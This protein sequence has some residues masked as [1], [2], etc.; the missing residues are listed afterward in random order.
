MLE[1]V[2]QNLTFLKFSVFI[3]AT[4]SYSFLSLV[5]VKI[6]YWNLDIYSPII[7]L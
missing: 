5:F 3:Q 4:F 7:I 6:L 2:L 1:R